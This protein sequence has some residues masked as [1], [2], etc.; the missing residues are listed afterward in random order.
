MIKI[1][2]SIDTSFNTNGN[3]VI[4]PLKLIETKKKSL[5]GWYINVEIPIE[6]KEYIQQDKL[7]VVKTKSKLRP[8]AF[9][10]GNIEYTQRKIIFT[11]NHVV[12]DAKD[13]F[14]A[15][16]RPTELNALN[17]LK[18]VSHLF[19]LLRNIKVPNSL[20]EEYAYEISRHDNKNYNILLKHNQLS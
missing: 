7:C 14:L 10:I 11:A 18:I 9:R 3:I 5:N 20:L 17:S 16:V 1:F 13:Y 2:D 19:F 6:Y 12:F 8:Q 15:D 4:N